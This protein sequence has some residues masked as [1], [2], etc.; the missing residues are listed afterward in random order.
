[1]TSQPCSKMSFRGVLYCWPRASPS[2]WPSWPGGGSWQPG[3]MVRKLSSGSLFKVRC[4]MKPMTNSRLSRAISNVFFWYSGVIRWPSELISASRR[5]ERTKGTSPRRASMATLSI[6]KASSGWKLG[7]GRGDMLSVRWEMEV[8]MLTTLCFLSRGLMP[9]RLSSS[10]PFI[11]GVTRATL[12]VL[13]ICSS[14]SSSSSSSS[15]GF[16][17]GASE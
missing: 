15:P 16:R 5:S 17:R 11:G 8:P 6:L 13:V 12:L 10:S 2:F 9:R 7:S 3:V 1:M 14:S 4:A